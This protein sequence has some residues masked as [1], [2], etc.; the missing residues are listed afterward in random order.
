MKM[1]RKFKLT[2]RSVADLKATGADYKAFDTLLPGF[3]VRVLPSGVKSYALFYRNA[4]GKQ[5]TLSLGRTN[6]RKAEQARNLAQSKLVDIQN[7]RDPSQERRA[8]RVVVT[9]QDLFEDYLVKHARVRKKARSVQGDEILWRLHLGPFLRDLRVDRVS[10]KD[11]HGFMATMVERKGAANRSMALLSKMMTL[12]VAWD[13]RPDNPCK[14][15]ERYPEN[16]MERFLT[17][18]E[19]ARLRASLDAEEDQVG[20]CAIRLLLLTG[21]R[22]SEVLKA[23]W[24]QFDL[25]G[26][27]PLWIVPQEHMKGATRIRRDLRRPISDEAA[28]LLNNLR[29]FSPVTSIHWVFPSLRDPSKCRADLN[30]LWDRVR[31]RAGIPDVRIHDLRHSFASAA[32]NSGA[33]LHMIGKALG[34]AD[35]RTTE[36]YAHVLDGSIRDVAESVS[37]AFAPR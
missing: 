11:L 5:R 26:T 17:A 16:R 10:L 2:E 29:V 6:L 9:M 36:R 14:R 1:V 33:S 19:V 28:S 4:D 32:I 23:T 12:A 24:S 8:E 22:R 20:S 18:A 21:A 7:G 15:V 30:K 27:S 3:H 31:D 13:L 35:V 25:S 37:R 34:H